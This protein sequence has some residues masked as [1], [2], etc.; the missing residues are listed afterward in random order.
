[1]LIFVSIL[2]DCEIGPFHSTAINFHFISNS[3]PV[4]EGDGSVVVGVQMLGNTSNSVTIGITSFTGTG[5]HAAIG[6]IALL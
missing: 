4:S 1:M 6:T 5:M 3:Y 2:S